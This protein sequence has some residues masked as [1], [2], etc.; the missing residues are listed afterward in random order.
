MP[1][2]ILMRSDITIWKVP[3]ASCTTW[4]TVQAVIAALIFEASSPDA[5]GV[6]PLGEIVAPH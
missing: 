3:A 4:P 1:L 2:L 6:I 5:G